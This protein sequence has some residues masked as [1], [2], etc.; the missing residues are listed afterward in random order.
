MARN[1]ALNLDIVVLLVTTLPL[2]FSKGCPFGIQPVIFMQFRPTAVATVGSN[3]QLYCNATT[4]GLDDLGGDPFVLGIYNKQKKLKS[5]ETRKNALECVLDFPNVNHA[6]GKAYFCVAKLTAGCSQKNRTLIVEDCTNRKADK[7]SLFAEFTE[8]NTI[9]YRWKYTVEN[10]DL[11]YH[12]YWAKDGPVSLNSSSVRLSLNTTSFEL[13]GRDSRT[14]YWVGMVIETS[15]GLSRIYRVD[16]PLVPVCTSRKYGSFSMNVTVTTNNTI[17]INWKYEVE[18]CDQRFFVYWSNEGPLSLVAKPKR[19]IDDMNST[20]L[21]INGLEPNSTYWIGMA[22]ST[23][24]GISEIYT[25]N[26]TLGIGVAGD[27]DNAD[28]SNRENDDITTP[29]VIFIVLIVCLLAVAGIAWITVRKRNRNLRDAIPATQMSNGAARNLGILFPEA[30]VLETAEEKPLPLKVAIDDDFEGNKKIVDTE[31][32]FEDSE[33]LTVIDEWEMPREVLSITSRKLGSGQ[34]GIVKKG[35]FRRSDANGE[36]IDIPVAVKVLRENATEI[37]RSDLFT[38]LRILKFVNVTPHKNILK[39]IGACTSEEPFAVV[40][41]F[42]LKGN[43][44]DVLKMYREIL[45]GTIPA[46]SEPRLTEEQLLSIAVDVAAGMKHLAAMQFVH[47][48]LAARNIL[49][50]ESWIAKISDF[51]LA[52]ETSS[53]EYKKY[54][55]NLLPVKWTAIEALVEG[56]FT[57]ASDVWSYGVLLWEISNIGGSPYKGIS[58]HDIMTHVGSGGRLSKPD[59]CSPYLFSIMSGCWET[60]PEKR[61]TFT[62]LHQKLSSMLEESEA[63]YINVEFMPDN[64][65][66]RDEEKFERYTPSVLQHS[67]TIK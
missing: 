48:D 47:R 20:S 3:I 17:S 24:K 51:G 19:I 49:V 18:H 25:Q 52:R 7:L 9:S 14:K 30:E 21:E 31:Q 53:G 16:N 37:D 38:E 62:V 58:P 34:F 59:R 40:T 12:V 67:A 61:P 44:K 57:S 56:K 2:V 54:R 15:K 45:N 13:R 11:V 4:M 1:M 10:C 65:E 42:C 23:T 6:D 26:V 35:T 36:N 60:F 41:E 50:T 64:D 46:S 43:L 66:R 28:K 33:Y 55:R 29:V 63:T 39:L 27:F 22:V 5:C 32:S 8:R